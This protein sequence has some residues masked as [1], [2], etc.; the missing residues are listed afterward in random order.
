MRGDFVPVYQGLCLGTPEY[1]GLGLSMSQ[2]R[3]SG[4]VD[5]D[6]FECKP[7]K[8]AI[9]LPIPFFFRSRWTQRLAE[10]FFKMWFRPC[11]QTKRH[12][13]LRLSVRWREKR[14]A[15][16]SKPK[17]RGASELADDLHL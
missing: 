7:R 10:M 9:C 11:D 12:H 4:H 6:G 2:H 5:R 17:S 13:R 8:D 16:E 15:K 14:D 1:R 3:V